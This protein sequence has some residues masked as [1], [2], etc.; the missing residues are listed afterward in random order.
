MIT[1]T[2]PVATDNSGTVTLQSRTH[3]PGQFFLSGITEVCYTFD[4]PS[5]NSVDCCLNVVVIEGIVWISAGCE[6]SLSSCV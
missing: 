5:L 3:V 1:F 6:P 2:E 4:D